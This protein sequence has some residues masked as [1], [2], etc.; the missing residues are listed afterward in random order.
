MYRGLCPGQNVPRPRLA[1]LRRLIEPSSTLADPQILDAGA[2]VLYFPPPKTV[3]GEDVLE[4]H[5][6]GGPAIVKAVLEAIPHCAN[7]AKTSTSWRPT[8]RY[9]EP[10]EFTKRAFYNS[11]LN[12]LQVEALGDSLAAETEQQRRL[13]VAGSGQVL[14]IR[15]EEWRRLLLYARG[16]LEAL[17]DFSEDQHL[18][19]SPQELLA[20]VAQQVLALRKQLSLHIQNASKGELVRHGIS[21]ALLGPPN[22]GKSSLLN[23]IIGREAAIVSDEAGTTRDIVDVGVDI[24]G[25]FCRFGDMAGLRGRASAV[26]S[27]KTTSFGRIEEEGIRR[28]RVR[29]LQ[30]DV[31]VVLLSIE[32]LPDTAEL[33]LN[34]DEE[35]VDAVQE[36]CNAGKAIVFAVNKIDKIAPIKE[37]SREDIIGSIVTDLQKKLPSARKHRI[38]TMS[39]Q[40]AASPVPNGDDPGKIQAFLEGLVSVLESLTRPVGGPQEYDKSYWEQSLSVSHRQSGFLQKCVTHLDDF[41]HTAS[42]QYDGQDDQVSDVDIVVAAENLRYAAECL[43]KITGKGEAGDVE[44]VLGVVFEK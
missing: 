28:A 43:S 36:C 41:V 3:T 35:V 9:A 42:P 34:L 18:D 4:F 44:D 17:I 37:Q 27:G 2:L 11:R 12:L 26:S 33:D 23:T 25:W 15:Y 14:A 5:L 32:Q 38:F 24:R 19:D 31:I 10:G 39:C 29:A 30:S 40:A 22:A 6:H 16:E 1:T 21:I 13:A 8:I 20:S 7:I